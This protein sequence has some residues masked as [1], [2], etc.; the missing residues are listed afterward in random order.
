[1][2]ALHLQNKSIRG[3]YYPGLAVGRQYD[4]FDQTAKP[5]AV[6]AVS[7]GKLAVIDLLDQHGGSADVIGRL[8]FHH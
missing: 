7:T 6:K 8:H 4:L 1:M 2:L 5:R 3:A